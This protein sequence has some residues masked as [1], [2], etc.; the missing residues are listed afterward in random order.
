MNDFSTADE[1]PEPVSHSRREIL[2]L[3][4][5]PYVVVLVLIVF[6]VAYTSIAQQP[7]GFYWEFVAFATGLL[8]VTTGWTK[9]ETRAARARLMWTQAAHWLAI[10]VAMTILF[11]PAV[12]LLLPAQ[13]SGLALLLLLALGTFLAGIHVAWEICLLGVVMAVLVPAIAWLKGNALLIVLAIA[14]GV[15]LWSIVWQRRGERDEG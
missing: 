10:L 15:G 6:G 12:Q 14:A 11:L 1:S 7:L 9:V 5:L 2:L 3:R 13:A 8:C 4:T